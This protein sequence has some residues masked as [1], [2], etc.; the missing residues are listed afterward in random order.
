MY[1]VSQQVVSHKP[2][3]AEGGFTYTGSHSRRLHIYGVSQQTVSHVQGFTAGR[4]A[5]REI[6]H[7]DY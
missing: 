7:I 1:K 4:K 5:E 6:N 2:G 3:L